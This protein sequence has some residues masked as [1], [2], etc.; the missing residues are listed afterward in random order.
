MLLKVIN[1]LDQNLLTIDTNNEGYYFS[2]R[3][4]IICLNN[5]KNNINFAIDNLDK[6][7][8]CTK[9]LKDSVSYL[10]ELYGKYDNEKELGFILASFVLGNRC[11]T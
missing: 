7:E 1:F 10:D 3:R 8:I 2:D 4:H 9:F 5:V 11:F 6:I